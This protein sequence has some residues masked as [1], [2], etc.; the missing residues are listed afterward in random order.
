ML[1]EYICQNC[2]ENL[3]AIINLIFQG[4]AIYEI[5]YDDNNMPFTYK[6]ISVNK[7]YEEMVEKTKEDIIGKTTIE[8]YPNINQLWREKYKEAVISGKK[9]EFD[10]YEEKLNKYLKVNVFKL[11]KNMLLALFTDITQK[12]LYEDSIEI[13]K[14]LFESAHDAVLYIKSNGQIIDANDAALKLYGYAYEELLKL[15]IHEIRHSS[16]RMLFKDQMIAADAEEGGIVFESTHV[17]K[18]GSSFP[19]EVSVRG[20]M[21][22]DE[23]L[24]IHI[25][26]DI[27]KRKAAEDKIIYL[28]NHDSLT[29]IANRGHLMNMLDREIEHAIRGEYKIALLLFDID[30]FK[31]INDIYGHQ[32]GDVVLKTVSSRVA[33]IIRKI[34]IVGRLGGDEFIIILPIKKPKD[35][36]NLVKRMFSELSKPI[37]IGDMEINIT[38]SIGIS[39]CPDH[40][41]DKDKIIKY[42]DEAMYFAKSL[43]GNGYFYYNNEKNS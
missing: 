14:L 9:I 42:A 11:N 12:K 21:I 26:R 33:D 13:H 40:G 38:I 36:L 37:S 30:N 20:I 39:I 23:R 4:Y 19:V 43:E 31:K 16:V 25:I 28:A 15:T 41:K 2:E 35:E 18:D 17:N 3:E 1:R 8:V 34:D 10:R 27:S 6:Y 22:R 32:A 24:R 7:Q 5:I 29:G